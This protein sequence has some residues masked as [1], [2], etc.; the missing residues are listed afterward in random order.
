MATL[1]KGMEDFL[2]KKLERTA[3]DGELSFFTGTQLY[4]NFAS[5]ETTNENRQYGCIINKESSHRLE[6][7]WIMP[8]YYRN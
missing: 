8:T 6:N 4:L 1:V 5:F 3:I 7:N 2:L